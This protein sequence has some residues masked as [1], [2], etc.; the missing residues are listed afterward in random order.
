MGASLPCAAAG[1]GQA[2]N[3]HDHRDLFCLPRVARGWE[4]LSLTDAATWQMKRGVQ[5]S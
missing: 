2:S 5:L 4:E 3:S 1:E